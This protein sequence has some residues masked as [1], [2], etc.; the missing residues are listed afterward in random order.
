MRSILN[1]AKPLGLVLV[2][3]LGATAAA[4]P[5]FEGSR[6]VGK[7]HHTVIELSRNE[8]L[9]LEFANGGAWDAYLDGGMIVVDGEMTEEQK[10]N[11]KTELLNPREMMV[12]PSEIGI[13]WCSGYYLSNVVYRG[14][15]FYFLDRR[16]TSAEGRGPITLT[17][18]VS[19]TATATY[20][21]NVGVSAEVVSAGVGYSFSTAYGVSSSA[22]WAV[23]SGVY[24]RLEAYALHNKHTW[25]VWDDDCGDPSD[26][27]KGNG[28]S[29]KPNGGV[30]FR[31]VTL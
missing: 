9:Q 26:T 12:A 18:T 10:Q 24:G 22:S 30:Y 7:A 25:D 31:K 1:G 14:N 5:N 15:S 21:A 16:L 11:Y 28:S 23:P 27:Y 13:Q 8:A 17:L 4:K 3:S 29:Y 19:K 6:S 20:S 2:L